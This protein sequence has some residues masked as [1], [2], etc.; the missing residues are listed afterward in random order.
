MYRFKKMKILRLLIWMMIYISVILSPV[1]MK[2]MAQTMLNSF[3]GMKFQRMV[4]NQFNPNLPHLILYTCLRSHGGRI[5][6]IMGYMGAQK[7]GYA[8]TSD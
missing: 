7:G 5:C 8:A 2:V 4:N 1:G 6:H 3:V